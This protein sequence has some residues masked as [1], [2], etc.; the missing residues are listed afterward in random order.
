MVINLFDVEVDY[1]ALSMDLLLA[2][3]TRW[4]ARLPRILP[5]KRVYPFPEFSGG[6]RVRS[7][8]F[9]QMEDTVAIQDYEKYLQETGLESDP[10]AMLSLPV[11]AWHE[12]LLSL[13]QREDGGF[14]WLE[15][16]AYKGYRKISL[17]L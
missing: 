10:R 11:E 17:I 1:Q 2:A 13:W 15:L 7:V 12:G 8:V 6:K 16:E 3:T 4:G 5:L 9:M 14:S